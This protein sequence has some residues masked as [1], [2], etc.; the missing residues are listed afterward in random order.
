[1][2]EGGHSL[3]YFSGDDGDH[4][5]YRRWKQWVQ[6]KV[7]TMDKL[8]KEAR[9]SFVFTLLQGRALEVVE[10]LEAS[11]YQKEDGDKVLFKL[12]DQRWPQKDRADELGE[13]VSEVFL[14]KAKEGETLRSWCARAM[15]VFDR[16]NRKTGVAFPEEARGWLVLNCSGMSE[17]Q[18]AVVL[19]RCHGSLKFDDVSQAMRSCYPEFVVPKRRSQPMHYVQDEEESWYDYGEYDGSEDADQGFNDV[20]MF[21]AEHDYTEEAEDT[22]VYQEAEVAEVLATTWREKRNELAKLQKARKFHQAKDVKRSFRVEV[23][24][25]KRRTQCHRCGKTGHWA[26]ECRQ[27]RSAAASSSAGASSTHASTP[28]GAG[29]VVHRLPDFICFVFPQ[30]PDLVKTGGMLE[31]LR[32]RLS[33][34]DSESAQEVLLVSSPGYAVLDSGCGKSVIGKETVKLFQPLLERAG[35]PSMTETKELNTFRYGNGHQ[36]TSQTVVDIPVIL[37]GKRGKVRAAVIQGSAPLLLSRPALKRLRARMDFDRDELL[38]FDEGISVPLQVNE[39]GQYMVPVAESETTEQMIVGADATAPEQPGTTAQVGDSWDVQGDKVVRI[40]NV[41]RSDLYTPEPDCPVPL[42]QLLSGRMTRAQEVGTQHPFLVEDDWRHNPDSNPLRQWVGTTTFQVMAPPEPPTPTAEECESG[43]SVCQWS[44]KQW[45]QFKSSAKQ[46]LQPDVSTPRD[47]SALDVVEVFSPPR[48]ASVAATKGLSCLSADLVTG[49]DFRRPAE[50]QLMFET[51]RKH[52]PKLLVL[53][54]PCTWAGG[55]FHLNRLYMSPRERQ[56]REMLTRLFANFSADLAQLQL[57]L[58]GRVM[59]EHPRGSGIW[60]LPKFIQLRQRLFEVEVDMCA[61]GMRIPDGLP[62]LK[63]TRLLVSHADMRSLSRKC[64][65]AHK[66]AEHQMVAGSHPKVGSVSKFAG[67]YPKAFVRSV[68]RTVKELPNTGVFLVQTGTD[69]ECLVAATVKQLNQQQREEMLRSLHRLHVNLGHPSHS[70]LARVLKHGGA[71]QAAIDLTR[72]IQCDVC[73]AQKPPASPPPAQTNRATRFNERIGLDVKYLSGWKPNQ[74]IPAL[75]IIDFA[76][77]YQ[78]MVPL[79]GRETGESLRQALQERWITWA[80]VPEEIVVD[81]AQTNLSEALTVPQEIAGSHISSTAAE[82][83]WQLGKVEVHG[84]W[85]GRVLDKVIAEA[86]PHNRDTWMECVYA[87]HSKNELIQVYGL[88]PAQFVFGRNPRV[89][90]DLLDEPL[91]VIPATASLY[92]ESL[93]RQVLVRQ[94]ARKAVIE[95]QDDKALRLSLLARPRKVQAYAPGSRVAYWRTQKSHEGV[96]ERGGRWYGPAVVLGYVGRNL[97]VIHKKQIL[98]CAPEQVRPS[99]PE[100]EQLVDTPGLEL[101][102]IKQMLDSGSIQSRQYEDLVSKG[103]PPVELPQVLGEGGTVAQQS[104]PRGC[105][106]P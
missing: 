105:P 56:E 37:A 104:S 84:G 4:R 12:L 103:H 36:E 64:P 32:S 58:G 3:R 62:I 55:W 75:N 41:P 69:R 15:E 38:L 91:Q 9:G 40:H 70:N 48:F 16:C 46:A 5:E 95:L 68:L 76:S 11:E 100:E 83:H 81:P 30:Q 34:S 96:I 74:R 102:G 7:L 86:M 98:R 52:K 21:L 50:R 71:S 89:P 101:L 90:S 80:G 59:F 65:G 29:L 23:E 25:L 97:V 73:K 22:E 72:E 28:A 45:R 87:A 66:H 67:Q 78:V 51:L 17:E 94:A 20:E 93:A 85:F 33:R 8:P 2:A 92:E 1:M 82:A 79:P 26:R 49:W 43:V 88:T 99:T 19:A 39:A 53:C 42:N 47:P 6:N 63:R 60:R 27:P 14:L 13:H 61:Y 18:R 57:E 77:S 31:L 44:R 10:H 106:S 54:P 35:L 24:E